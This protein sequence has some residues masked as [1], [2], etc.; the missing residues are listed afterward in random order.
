MRTA[1]GR[2]HGRLFVEALLLSTIAGVVSDL[3]RL[4]FLGWV[5]KGAITFFA[6]D[7]VSTPACHRNRGDGA[8]QYQQL[9]KILCYSYL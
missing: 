6:T 9:R 4:Q 7:A 8:C 1:I 3:Q 5:E 2:A